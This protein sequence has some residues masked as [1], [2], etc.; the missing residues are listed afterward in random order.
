MASNDELLLDALI[1]DLIKVRDEFKWANNVTNTER[2]SK[3]PDL[4]A[5]KHGQGHTSDP[6]GEIVG[7]MEQAR[8][9]LKEA[10]KSLR[11]GI[12][13]FQDMMRPVYRDLH[14]TFRAVDASHERTDNRLRDSNLKGEELTDAHDAKRRR[15]GR[16]EGFGVA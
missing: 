14:R 13:K 16:G 6:T 2:V 1:D 11:R 9:H 3:G 12:Y 5:D 15:G 7:S 10:R 8:E 4:N